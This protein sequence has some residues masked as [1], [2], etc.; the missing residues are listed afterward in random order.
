MF[1]AAHKLA[2]FDDFKAVN[3]L[4]KLYVFEDVHK[5]AN[6]SVFKAI[7]GLAKRCIFK[8]YTD[9]LKS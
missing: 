7:Y 2:N 3:R 9:C 6:I 4:V 5:L 1:E 8:T